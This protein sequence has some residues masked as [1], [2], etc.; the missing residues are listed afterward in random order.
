MKTSLA[1][2][3]RTA[4]VACVISA[5]ASAV[6]VNVAQDTT[7]SSDSQTTSLDGATQIGMTQITNGDFQ[8]YPFLRFDLSGLAGLVATG[9]GTL[10]LQFQGFFDS[11]GNYPH[12]GANVQ[13]KALPFAFDALTTYANYAGFSHLLGGIHTR[14]DIDAYTTI[15]GSQSYDFGSGGTQ[16]MSF[17]VPQATLQ[18]WIDTPSA[19][20]GFTLFRAPNPSYGNLSAM[21]FSS[22]E[23]SQAP[24][25]SFSTAIPEP[26]AY[27]AIAGSALLGF[28]ALRRHRGVKALVA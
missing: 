17:T 15:G 13:L 6:T 12:A 24:A 9:D 10:T 25:L 14:S 3:L 5:A 18:S 7:V 4:L 27:A 2:T 11:G 21:V 20:L 8:A 16:T 26:S 28:A 1:A 23:G 19:N 22:A